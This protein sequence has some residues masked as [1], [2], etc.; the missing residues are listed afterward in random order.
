MIVRPPFEG[1]SL[2]AKLVNVWFLKQPPAEAHRNR[3]QYLANRIAE[4]TAAALSTGRVARILSLGCGPAWEVQQFLEEKH[5]SNNAS[6][7]LLD[8]NVETLDYSRSTLENIKRKHS[9]TTQF[10]YIKRSVAQIA[11][12]GGRTFERSNESQY[13][14]IFCAGLFDYLPD[15]I[16]RR[17]GDVFYGWLAPGGL[18]ITTNVD[19]YN[20]RRLTME[21]VM[22]WHLI[23]RTGAELAALKPELARPDWCAVRSDTTGVNIYFEATK[24]QRE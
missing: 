17:L 21:Y 19:R 8:F 5:F 4:S 20:P 13:D 11:K 2:F 22:D 1:A 6:F 23:Y 12:D 7:A 10:Q 9:R 15:Q 14:L 3:I 16:C 18:L 24:P